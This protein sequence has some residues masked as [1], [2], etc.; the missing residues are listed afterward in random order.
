[1]TALAK[2]SPYRHLFYLALLFRTEFLHGGPVRRRYF[3]SRLI[4]RVAIKFRLF[5]IPE[6]MFML[7][8]AMRCMTKPQTIGEREWRYRHWFWATARVV[9]R[10]ELRGWVAQRAAYGPKVIVLS[11]GS[12]G[13][14]LQITPVLRALREKLPTAEIALFHRSLIAK[15]ILGGNPNVDLII[16]EAD[17]YTF[18]QIKKSVETEG[19]ADLV[20]DIQ[21]VTYLIHYTRAPK[22]M[23]H[24]DV[25]RAMP[26]EFFLKAKAGL[27][28]WQN[29]EKQKFDPDTVS[30]WP[31]K[32][33]GWH[34]LDVLGSTG[35]L[36]I[37]KDSALDFLIE[38]GAESILGRLPSGLKYITVQN[39]VDTDVMNWARVT[40]QYP[41]K[42]LPLA[43]W[44]DTLKQLR[45]RDV[46]VIQLGG[47]DDELIDGVS[48]DLRGKTSL[49]EAAI[50]LKNAV[51][52][53]GTEG[54]LVHLA[55]AVGGTSVVLF[56]AT[57]I[58]FFGYTNNVNLIATECTGCWRSTR[59]WYIY[60]PRGLAEAVCMTA[61]Q[62]EKI[63][64]AVSGIMHNGLS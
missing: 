53:V 35:N 44:N 2:K 61:F 57:A 19:A 14:V 30:V 37:N 15:K 33:C 32:W 25:D 10:D 36:P 11:T 1:V 17:F 64:E 41:S 48:L 46:F 47:V 24:P 54:G 20:V 62:P 22:D 43:I 9:G 7:F 63:V 8:H 28:L 4:D 50:L 45:A 12:I 56:G 40:G 39:G 52:H 18:D 49:G 3:M 59:D 31:E 38:R 29:P 42:L 6:Y 55:R 34:F 13:D 26:E 16:E 51:C 58:D 27:V 60:C 5:V 21:S 23:R